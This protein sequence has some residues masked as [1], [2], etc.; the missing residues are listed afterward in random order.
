MRHRVAVTAGLAAILLACA[1]SVY[2]QD[3]SQQSVMAPADAEVSAHYLAVAESAAAAPKDRALWQ[4]RLDASHDTLESA[5][6]MYTSNGQGNQAL[7]L[8]VAL[9]RFWRGP[10]LVTDFDKALSLPATQ[11]MIRARALNSASA[12]AFRLK[13]QE[14]T[15]GWANES[16]RIWRSL[17]NW[18]E[19]GRAYERLVQA[20]L[21]DDNHSA[22]RAY[23]DTGEMLCIQ[24][25]DEDCHAYF[26]N[27]RG[28]SARVLKEYDSAAVYYD[29][30]GAIYDRVS[31]TPRLDIAHNI[32]F[33]LLALGRIAEARQ[34]FREGLGRAVTSMN[35]NYYPF[36]L[37][38][39]A[40]SDAV[41]G[42]AAS[43]ARLFGVSDALLEKLQ[44][45]ADPADAVEYER[46]RAIARA[47]LGGAAFEA[48][49]KTGRGLSADSVIATFK[50]G[51]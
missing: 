14:R 32:G 2:G 29:R 24:A 6:A 17:G 36:M 18:A 19:T 15:R 40:S 4:R 11:P 8:L 23:A 9:S 33:T 10:S 16:I 48:G 39:L 13:D 12:A 7:R 51:A 31:P 26:L 46:Y 50:T 38:G 30:A 37:A 3:P 5:F 28:E 35:R 21:R 49:V 42:N 25:H 44:I 41:D 47:R 27:M 22:L 45:V 20:A 43:A 34:R 1:R